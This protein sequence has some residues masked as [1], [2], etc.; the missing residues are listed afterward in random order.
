MKGERLLLTCKLLT[1]EWDKVKCKGH[2]RRSWL[3][4]VEFSKKEL[5]LQDQILDIKLIKK[6]LDKSLTT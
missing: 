4:Q 3:A 2:S 1:N 5:G 6:A